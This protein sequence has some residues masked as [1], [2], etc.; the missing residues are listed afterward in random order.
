MLKASECVSATLRCSQDQLTSE[1]QHY[2][3]QLEEAQHNTTALLAELNTREQLLQR[4]SET[5]LIKV[6][7]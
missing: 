5:L 6:E 3:L 7:R 1:L 4:T 2:R